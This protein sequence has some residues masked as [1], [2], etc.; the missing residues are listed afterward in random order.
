[1]NKL[2][3]ALK[4]IHE[5]L[6][7][8]HLDV[9]LPNICFCETGDPVLIDSDRVQSATLEASQLSE[10][11]SSDFYMPEPNWMM[12][13]VD[14]KQLGHLIVEEAKQQND[15]I[16]TLIETGILTFLF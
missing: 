2:S 15:F 9:H 10:M 8:V 7:V 4:R 1:M 6:K 14:C 13:N 3:P 5:T 12:H 16:R 11:Y